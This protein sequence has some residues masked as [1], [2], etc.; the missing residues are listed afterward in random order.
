M[1]GRRPLTGRAPRGPDNIARVKREGRWLS[2][3][4]FPGVPGRFFFNRIILLVSLSAILV[5]AL[6]IFALRSLTTLNEGTDWV[7]HT[8]T[9]R[10]QLSHVLQLL[11]DMGGGVRRFEMTHDEH[12]V[13]LELSSAGDAVLSIAEIGSASDDGTAPVANP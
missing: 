9:V 11:V 12:S 7:V 5:V 10:Y 4:T 6:G 13:H 2:V 1:L 3:P 8:Q